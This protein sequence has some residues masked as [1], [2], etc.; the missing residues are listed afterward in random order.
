MLD[1]F[2]DETKSHVMHSS[3]IGKLIIQLFWVLVSG[4]DKWSHLGDLF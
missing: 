1:I 2:P 4:S 3:V